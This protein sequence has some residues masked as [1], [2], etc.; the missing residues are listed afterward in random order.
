MSVT[1]DLEDGSECD[2][3]RIN[4]LKVAALHHLD[5]SGIVETM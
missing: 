1:T 2:I 3:N 4:Y 5:R